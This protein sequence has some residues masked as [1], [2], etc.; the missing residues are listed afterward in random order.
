MPT[1]AAI[2]TRR[3]RGQPTRRNIR[4]S[5]MGL[6]HTRQRG[7][8]LR[9]VRLNSRTTSS[10]SL[11]LRGNRGQSRRQGRNRIRSRT[12]NTNLNPSLG[13]RIGKGATQFERKRKA[14]ASAWAFAACEAKPRFILKPT[15]V[16]HGTAFHSK[17]RKCNR[18]SFPFA[19]LSVRM[20]NR[21]GNKK[22]SGQILRRCAFSG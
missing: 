13:S 1:A 18:G 21:A 11:G 15:A 22:I 10:R 6:R 5:R 14:H 4:R 16:G 8:S 19:S 3:V 17:R 7:I 9:V 2:T 12:R 20:T